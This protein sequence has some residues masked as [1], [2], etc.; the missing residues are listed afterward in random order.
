MAGDG[1]SPQTAVCASG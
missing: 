1:T